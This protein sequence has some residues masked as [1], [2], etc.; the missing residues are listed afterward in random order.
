[1]DNR[2]KVVGLSDPFRDSFR[3]LGLYVRGQFLLVVLLTVIYA[4]IFAALQVRFWY[5]IAIVGGLSSLIPRIGSLVPLGLA[6]LAL[7]IANAPVASYL[8]LLG[9]W[10]AVQ[11][12]EYL[13]LLPRLIGKPLGLMEL[14]VLAA[15]LVGSLFFGPIGIL[16]AVPVLAV[17]MVFW[18]YFRRTAK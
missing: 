1:V 14:P 7:N 13:V 16:L 18:R 9:G 12:L 4:A 17:G 2:P 11:A 6:A 10:I 3:V 8:W 15:L 5:A